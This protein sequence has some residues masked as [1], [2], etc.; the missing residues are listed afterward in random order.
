MA[1]DIKNAADKI[2]DAHRFDKMQLIGILHDLQAHQRWLP[3]E[4][5][6][7]LA[8]KLDL[9]I[10][11]IYHVA[12]FF[13][14]FYLKPR[15][16]H[17]CTVCLGT[18]CHVRGAPKLLE[19]LERNLNIKAGETTPDL[20]FSLEAVNCVGACALGPVVICDGEYHGHMTN[21]KTD[22]LLRQVKAKDKEENKAK[23]LVEA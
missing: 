20:M 14:A 7:Y 4:V 3:R 6:E 18:A 22:R 11:Q 8:E 19:N 10:N 13:K 2:I 23:E 17:T 21:I 1:E 5:L 16:K 15:G 9:P 12:T